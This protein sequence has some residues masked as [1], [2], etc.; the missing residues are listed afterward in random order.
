MYQLRK[1]VKSQLELFNQYTYFYASDRKLCYKKHC[2]AT[3]TYASS[4]Y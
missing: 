2:I 4:L 1:N 3:P